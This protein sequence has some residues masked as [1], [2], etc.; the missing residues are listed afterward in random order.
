[1][2]A[3]TLATAGNRRK[4]PKQPHGGRRAAFMIECQLS[5]Q[6]HSNCQSER[7]LFSSDPIQVYVFV[8]MGKF[9]FQHIYE[10]PW[11]LVTHTHLTKYP[12]EKE[13]NIVGTQITDAKKG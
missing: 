11:E 4:I 5:K 3:A 2:I 13:K 6:S 12:T 7:Y 1:M 8:N 9:T 10:F